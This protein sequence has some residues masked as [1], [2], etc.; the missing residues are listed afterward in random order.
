MS[1]TSD[2]ACLSSK[3]RGE[4]TLQQSAPISILI[5]DDHAVL[6][7]GLRAILETQERL[8]VVGEAIDSSSALALAT[9]KQPDIVLLDLDLGKEN[10]FDLIPGLLDA[11]PDTRVLVLTGVRDPAAHERIVLLG[12]M[13]IV[14]K[15]TALDLILKAIDKVYAG[16]V[17]LDR[18]MI[19]SI[20]NTRVRTNSSQEHNARDARIATLTD[21][22]RE[23]IGLIG[24]GLRNKVIA[25]RLVISEATVRNHLTSIFAKLGVDDRFELVV[26]AYQNHLAQVPE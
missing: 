9:E 1:Y 4:M 10:G 6:R 5:V 14:L 15:E 3:Y 2:L 11:A 24:E 12:A 23:I 17:W 18:T 7:F 16:E 21:R 20:L 8:A 22:E 26:F 25:E 13:G 19:A